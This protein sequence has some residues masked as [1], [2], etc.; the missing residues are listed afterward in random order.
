[1]IRSFSEWR[2]RRKSVLSPCL[3]SRGIASTFSPGLSGLF[4]PFSRDGP[5]ASKK[6]SVGKGCLKQKEEKNQVKF[7]QLG[8]I[9]K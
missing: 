1:M 3:P 9:G 8:E 5:V 2:F 4:R 7:N 6:T